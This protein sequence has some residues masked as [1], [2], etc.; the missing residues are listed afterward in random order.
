VSVVVDT[1][2]G[3]SGKDPVRRGP[4]VSAGQLTLFA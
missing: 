4:H 2:I 1:G 3:I